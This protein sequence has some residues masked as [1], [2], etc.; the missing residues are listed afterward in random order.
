MTME[1]PLNKFLKNPSRKYLK[2]KFQVL[3]MTYYKCNLNV[4]MNSPK[5]VNQ[6]E[7]LTIDK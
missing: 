3:K 2:C 6:T 5:C 1:K 4:S 7:M